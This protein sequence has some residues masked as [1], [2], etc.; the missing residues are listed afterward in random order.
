MWT[1]RYIASAI[2]LIVL[3]PHIIFLPEFSC[4]G[5]L[6]ALDSLFAAV[7][8]QVKNG[9]RVI[10]SVFQYLSAPMDGHDGMRHINA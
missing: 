8:H 1:S 3:M 5:Y 2:N 9:T 10:H 7:T 4:F 6:A